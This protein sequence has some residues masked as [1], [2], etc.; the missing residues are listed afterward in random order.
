MDDN[1]S[2]PTSVF[3]YAEL[4]NGH[5][6]I[7]DEKI[8]QMFNDPTFENAELKDKVEGEQFGY[9]LK[10]VVVATA[11]KKKTFYTP[12]Q[13]KAIMKYRDNHRNEYNE[14][15]RKLYEKLSG[16]DEWVKTR[17]EKAKKYN[18]DYRMK[19][20]NE[21]Y[22]RLKAEATARGETYAEVKK[23]RG[24]PRKITN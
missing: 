14:S 16:N 8:N 13:K 22:E 21:N 20:A 19:K 5:H 2:I 11:H 4:I 24:R 3:K 17:N 15:Q 7:K 6:I 9:G 23:G 12:A 18:K 10:P 1:S